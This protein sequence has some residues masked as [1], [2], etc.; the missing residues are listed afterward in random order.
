M[1]LGCSAQGEEGILQQPVRAHGVDVPSMTMLAG[2]TRNT[3][4]EKVL[5]TILGWG[6]LLSVPSSQ[7]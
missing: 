4:V 2:D 1:L 7:E 5:G 6:Q 3:P